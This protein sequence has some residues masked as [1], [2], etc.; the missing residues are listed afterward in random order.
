L[1]LVTLAVQGFLE[2]MASA[3]SV[4]VWSS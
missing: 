3:L 2:G 1:E 4:F